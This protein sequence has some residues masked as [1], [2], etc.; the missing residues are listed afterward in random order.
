MRSAFSPSAAGDDEEASMDVSMDTSTTSPK[1]DMSYDEL[2][3]RVCKIAKPLASEKLTKKLHKAV[4]RAHKAK[5]LA[6]GVKEV[7]KCIR[8]G[9][10]G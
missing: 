3:A 8:K 2:L 1:E 10:K 9:E 4:E 5:K 7:G 6:R